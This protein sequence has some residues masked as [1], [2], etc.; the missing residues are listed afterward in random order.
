MLPA[1]LAL[2]TCALFI[3]AFLWPYAIGVKVAFCKQTTCALF[4][5]A[6]F[7]PYAI[8]VKVAFCKQNMIKVIKKYCRLKKENKLSFLEKL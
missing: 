5:S 8:G 1:L 2:T 4:I 6:F 3:S 7:W